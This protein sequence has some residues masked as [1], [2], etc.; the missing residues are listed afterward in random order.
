MRYL[1]VFITFLLSVTFYGQNDYSM[2]FDGV[3]DYIMINHSSSIDVSNSIS[4][5]FL[6]KP[7][8][9][10]AGDENCIV[11]KKYGDN[12]NGFVIYNDGNVTPSICFRIEGSNGPLQDYGESNAQVDIGVWQHWYFVYNSSSSVTTIYK[13]GQL[14]TTRTSINVGDMSTSSDLYIALVQHP[15]WNGFYE[16]LLDDVTLWDIPLTSQEIQSYMS[17]PPTGNEEG[18]VGY[19]N[20]EEGSGTTAYDLTGNGND[21]AINGA[22][23]STDV[24]EQNCQ[25]GCTDTIACNFNENAVEDDGSCEYITPVD[26]GEDITTC[27]ELVTLD[28]GEGYDSYLWSNGETTQTI[29]VSESGDYSV[30]VGVGNGSTNDYSMSFDGVANPM[31]GVDDYVEV[32][33]SSSMDR[34]GSDPF[35]VSANVSFSS[36]ISPFAL[37]HT[38]TEGD[39]E[40]SIRFNISTSTIACHWEHNGGSNYILSENIDIMG[41]GNLNLDEWTNITFTWD[42]NVCHVT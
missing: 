16:G 29:D 20:F 15:S 31:D 39:P 21:G 13:N 27:D 14:D 10:T 11:S 28:A 38:G 32:P 1:I 5:G 22:T 3:D 8:S 26:L 30:E 17:C 19:W 33:Y 23:Y 42:G 35:T 4:I 12:N 40:N 24:P 25:S 34:T 7:N 41:N 9:W 36:D 37:F 2:S 18:L 6:M